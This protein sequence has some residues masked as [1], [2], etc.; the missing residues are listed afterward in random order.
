MVVINNQNLDI[1]PFP[2][3]N[4]LG[5]NNQ[6]NNP[7]NSA[8]YHK[9]YDSNSSIKKGII[10]PYKNKLIDKTSLKSLDKYSIQNLLNKFNEIN[11]SKYQTEKK[12]KLSINVNNSE[13]NYN[14]FNTINAQ[15][16]TRNGNTNKEK[17]RYLILHNNRKIN[18]KNLKKNINNKL[19]D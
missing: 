10:S 16:N 19:I 5:F 9:K 1:A 3:C 4:T 14:N 17:K 2:H 8:R 13:S 15:S 12:N 7:I 11:D 18:I 6:N